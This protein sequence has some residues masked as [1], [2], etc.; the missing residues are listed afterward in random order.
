LFI[1]I[2][3]ITRIRREGLFR[4]LE[5]FEFRAALTVAYYSSAFASAI[6]QHFP[7]SPQIEKNIILPQ[8]RS[9]I[10]FSHCSAAKILFYH[11]SAAKN[12]FSHYSA[13]KNLF[14]HNSAAKKLFSHNSAAKVK[15]QILPKFTQWYE[16]FNCFIGVRS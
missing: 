11:N 7:T 15:M 5:D 14:S 1:T 8:F 3:I 2:K 10:L 9:K 6:P 16:K 12:L 4:T 13:E